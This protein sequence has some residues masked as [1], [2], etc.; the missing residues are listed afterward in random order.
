MVEYAGY[1]LPI[2]YSGIIEEHNIVRN[3]VGLLML[4]YGTIY[5]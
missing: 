2:Q 4:S 1:Y 3:N 5:Y